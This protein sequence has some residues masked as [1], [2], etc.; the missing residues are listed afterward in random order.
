MLRINHGLA[1][2]TI[3]HADDELEEISGA[4]LASRSEERQRKAFLREL[5]AMMRLRSPHTVRV[6]GKITSSQDRL[7]IVMELLVGGD[8]RMLLRNSTSPLPEEK[9]QRII[10][11]VCAGM[12][13]LHRM[14][15]IHGDLK[16]ANV[17]LDGAGRAKVGLSQ[18]PMFGI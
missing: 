8:L 12:A 4:S 5:R 9:A 6:Y 15:N 1:G 17:L 2:I 11:D 16:S 7:V 14:E 13:F 10:G 18:H 3:G